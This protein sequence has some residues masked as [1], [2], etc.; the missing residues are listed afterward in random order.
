MKHPES[1]LIAIFL[2]AIGARAN[3]FHIGTFCEDGICTKI[4][5]EPLK[6]LCRDLEEYCNEWVEEGECDYNPVYIHLKCPFSCG[7]CPQFACADE[8]TNCE[9]WAFDGECE[10][11][12]G[13]MLSHCSRSCDTCKGKYSKYKS[14]CKDTLD[15]CPFYVSKGMCTLRSSHIFMLNNC[16]LACEMCDALDGFDKC[17]GKRDPLSKSCLEKTQDID[18][19]IDVGADNELKSKSLAN[20][21]EGLALDEGSVMITQPSKDDTNNDPYI[22]QM[23]HVFSREDCD[24]I[25]E[26][27]NNIGWK[28][29]I[30]NRIDHFDNNDDDKNRKQPLQL[31]VRSS[32]S[33]ICDVSHKECKELMSGI[34][35]VLSEKIG[36]SIPFFEVGEIIHYSEGDYY[37]AHHNHKLSD[38]YKPAGPRILT[39]YMTLSEA[40]S[41]GYVGFPALDWLLVDPNKQ[42]SLLLWPNADDDLNIDARMKNEVMPVRE[43]DLYLLEIH[44]HLHDYLESSKMGCA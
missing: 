29:S 28:D 21:F 17:V 31:P 26:T 16:P 4:S 36:V 44:V 34:I 3:E 37:S 15:E 6:N 32:K 8:H 18:I 38:E 12:P 5:N 10:A 2:W 23:N 42:G 24:K 43:G 27:A 25:I 11:N 41:G 14:S 39:M 35:S 7:I 1:S 40:K 13:Y 19:D 20:L 9:L 33:V 30:V 22:L